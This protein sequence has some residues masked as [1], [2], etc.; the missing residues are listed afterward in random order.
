MWSLKWNLPKDTAIVFW[1][2]ED[3]SG[4]SYITSGSSGSDPNT[5]KEDFKNCASSWAP[6]HLGEVDRYLVLKELHCHATQ[7]STEDEI[8]LVITPDFKTS[9]QF[10]LKQKMRAL[11]TWEFENLSESTKA[12][13]R[14]AGYMGEI[15]PSIPFKHNVKLSLIEIDPANPDD[16]I[17]EDMVVYY[18]DSDDPREWYH[19]A[20]YH[21]DHYWT[22]SR[23]VYEIK[24]NNSAVPTVDIDLAEH[25][26]IMY[27]HDHYKGEKHKIKFDYL[28]DGKYY[29][30]KTSRVHDKMSSL[31]WNMPPL[32]RLIFY[33]HYKIA[34]KYGKKQAYGS[35]R[36][37]EIVGSGSDPNTEKN[38]NNVD[39]NDCQSA[40]IVLNFENAID[41]FYFVGYPKTYYKGDYYQVLDI[42]EKEFNILYSLEGTTVYE[43]LASL[44]WK[45][46]KGT[47]IVFFENHD[48]TGLDISI[49]DKGTNWN[50]G[51]ANCM[52][53]WKKLKT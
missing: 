22:S 6:I 1:E 42:K 23:L 8:K 32:K 15:Y 24:F 53:S 9:K 49:L 18:G 36:K 27:E 31:K 26:F 39:F 28:E 35:G 12:S 41:A 50:T 14:A 37:Y 47:K 16:R 30:L 52:R 40:F 45:L 5:N 10:T 21:K 20:W 4:R 38:A 29:S 2:H 11:E 34:D 51:N 44:N 48:G 33:E 3:G 43:K 46:P 19:R 25:Y 17:G 13:L 7:E